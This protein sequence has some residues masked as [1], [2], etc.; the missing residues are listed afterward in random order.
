MALLAYSNSFH[1]GFTLDN[2]ILLQERQIYEA[3]R[4]NVGLI[5]QHTY[6]WPT[7]ESGLYRPL[8]I[9]SFLFNYAVLGNGEHPEGYHWINFLF[10]AANIVLAFAITRRLV[11]GVLPAVFIAGIWGVHPLLTDA[12]TNI[13]GRADLLAGLSVLGGFLTYLKFKENQGWQ[14]RT[15]L[16]C[17]FLAA[18]IG[19]FSKESAVTL[20]GVIALYELAWWKERGSIH[21]VM[22]GMLATI[23]PLAL[24]LYQR[25]VVL[26]AS[27]AAVFPF[28]DNP[29]ISA[30]FWTARLIALR[31]MA[32][33]L[34]LILWPARLSSDYSYAQIPL[35]TGA[36]GDWVAWLAVWGIGAIVILLYRRKPEVFFFGFLAFG[37]FLPASNLLFPIG[38]IMAERLLY[39][40]AFG[41]I[42]CLV[43]T[44]YWIGERTGIRWLAT[45]VLLAAVLGLA[46]RTWE[47]NP[48]WD[49]NLT[50]AES[51][52]LAVPGSFKAH[53]MLSRALYDADSRSNLERAI[54]EGER[55]VAVLDSL[56]DDRNTWSA[57]RQLAGYY[58]VKGDRTSAKIAWQRATQLLNRA[59]PILAVSP[60]AAGPAG[61]VVVPLDSAEAYR[62]LAGAWL[63]VG[64]PAKAYDAAMRARDL[65]PAASDGYRSLGAAL[66]AL[67]REEDA[68]VALMEGEMLTGDAGLSPEVV[69][70]YQARPDQACTLAKGA[71]GPEP[72]PDCPAVRKH[73][74]A[75]VAGAA[76]IQVQLHREGQ[77]TLMM[78][79]AGERYGCAFNAPR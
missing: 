76:R 23:P 13:V 42:A 59:I 28:L 53:L 75:A 2:A 41:L 45:A 6:W 60:P 34:M 32:R 4:Q 72:N 47:R 71:S 12:V 40:P 50:L 21:D 33:Y 62:T 39:L 29:L 77:A 24:F 17:L 1:A 61:E 56:P 54:R 73:I 49:N 26:A 27:P 18:S 31:I 19:F 37:T 64:D 25:S 3:T 8:T 36:P 74:C 69:R 10:H 51:E 55:A 68:I 48:D 67:G 52:V 57:Y 43:L 58:L 66:D 11:R 44:V 15:W 79:R 9:L 78:N 46:V 20:M 70:I 30:H 16:V 65:N 5:L 22:A 14:R 63:R 35:S 7:G 38:T